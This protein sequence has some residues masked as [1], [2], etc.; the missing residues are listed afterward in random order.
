MWLLACLHEIQ[1]SLKQTTTTD[2]F[3]SSLCIHTITGDQKK[4]MPFMKS[5]AWHHS[6]LHLFMRSGV[7][8]LMC[9]L[10][11]PSGCCGLWRGGRN[12]YSTSLR[13]IVLCWLHCRANLFLQ[14]CVHVIEQQPKKRRCR[15]RGCRLLVKAKTNKKI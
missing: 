10:L 15:C 4:L 13:T 9:T 6:S 14:I 5:L 3:I 2:Q 11:P 1:C 8:P 7:F 12:I